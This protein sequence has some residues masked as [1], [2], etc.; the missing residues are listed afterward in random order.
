MIESIACDR[1]RRSRR[2]TWLDWLVSLARSDMLLARH[3]FQQSL[4]RLLEL[5]PSSISGNQDLRLEASCSNTVA[6]AAALCMCF[7]VSSLLPTTLPSIR[8]CSV[9]TA[10]FGR[11]ARF[12][13]QLKPI[14]STTVL[15]EHL[16]ECASRGGWSLDVCGVV[17]GE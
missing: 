15:I 3:W 5:S 13:Q 17:V 2:R 11:A 9:R 16:H 8:A 7:I 1:S 6:D 12:L 4:G 10:L 14:A